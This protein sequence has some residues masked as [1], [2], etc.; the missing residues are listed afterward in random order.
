MKK[1]ANWQKRYPTWFKFL[2]FGALAILLGLLA[3]KGIFI[4]YA[5]DDY[6]YGA[7][8]QR[9]GFL[10]TQSNSYLNQMP[11][12]SNRFSLTFSLSVVEILGASSF[13]ALT[14]A[15]I[16]VAL[17]GGIYGL[18]SQLSK[19]TCTHLD[20]TSKLILALGIPFFSFLLTPNLY[21]D[22][23]WI[24]GS[25]TYTLPL[26]FILYQ[27]AYFI[28]LTQ[29]SQFSFWTY[30]W[31]GLISFFSSGFSETTAVWQFSLLLFILFL[32]LLFKKRQLKFYLL[33]LSMLVGSLLGLI[34][35][36]ISPP[37]AL[38]MAAGHLNQPDFF[39]LVSQSI[40]NNRIFINGSIKFS[41]TEFF[42]IGSLSVWLAW[43]S[44]ENES[45]DWKALLLDI[46]LIF[47][48]GVLLILAT[49]VPSMYAK[50]AYPG[51]RA[52]IPGMFTLVCLVIGVSWKGTRLISVLNLSDYFKKGLSL[53]TTIMALF[54]I[55]V[56]WLRIPEFSK[57]IPAFA[58]RAEAWDKR[59]QGLLS[60]NASNI[61]HMV[62]PV[63]DSIAEVPDFSENEG[64]WINNCAEAYY[65]IESIQAIE[66][67][68]G[69][70]AHP[71][72]P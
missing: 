37:N 41:L 26:V 30:L 4:R 46:G 47:G 11:F 12:N 54:V 57:A 72:E 71:V 22:L 50:S 61:Q 16:I 55:G 10:K 60:A 38:D 65:G 17:I 48:I 1:R 5:A 59:H 28:F 9:F 67:Y 6:C 18:I 35:L 45:K 49:M 14:P 53:L 58:A 31:V 23:Y 36:A 43:L 62:V 13:A 52:L 29:K 64:F 25:F 27:I 56:L 34:L 7:Q 32:G 24:S 42:A 21:Q 8:V 19:L 33:L 70:S 15:L 2:I 63:F 20:T 51:E 69:V 66:N 40:T 44:R 39:K 3:Y 68:N